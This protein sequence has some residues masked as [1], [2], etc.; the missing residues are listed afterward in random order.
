MAYFGSQITLHHGREGTVVRKRQLITHCSCCQEA[1]CL[2]ALSLFPPLYSAQNPSPWD[3][4][5]H[6]QDGVSLS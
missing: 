6:I 5:T 3:D 4:A 2:L 1:G